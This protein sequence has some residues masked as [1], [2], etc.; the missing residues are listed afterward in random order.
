MTI[1]PIAIEVDEEEA[2]ICHQAKLVCRC[3]VTEAK[4]AHI[5]GESEKQPK[6]VPIQCEFRG[7]PQNPGSIRNCLCGTGLIIVAGSIITAAIL[8][9][10]GALGN[11]LYQFCR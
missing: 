6:Q 3:G 8:F 9:S 7:I 11:L 10:I 5:S 1:Q 2:A 4:F